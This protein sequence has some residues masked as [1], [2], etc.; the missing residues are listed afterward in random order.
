MVVKIYKQKNFLLEEINMNEIKPEFHHDF[1]LLTHEE[2]VEAHKNG[3][4]VTGFVEKVIADKQVLEVRLGIGLVAILPFAEATIYPLRYSKKKASL[5]P[6]NIRCLIKRK[7]R[8]K[9]TEVNGDFIAVSR[10]QNMLEALE[11]IRNIK[12]TPMYITNVIPKSVFGD[13]GEGIVGKIIINEVCRSHIKNV[14][15]YLS[16][17]Q[18]I[19][20]VILEADDEQRFNVS[21]RQAFK[22][23]CQEDYSTGMVVRGRIGDW[24]NITDTSHYYVNIAPQVSG[25]LTIKAHKHLE[26][27]TNVECIVTGTCEK[28]LYLELA[29]LL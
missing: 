24:I 19:D 28:G 2:I 21:Y 3:C 7:I 1:A 8:V 6:T 27:G 11:Y 4:T 26:Y 15:E 17:G 5:L 10:K 14:R 29:K 13:I 18:T 25:I 12:R 20:V 22:P 23:Y 16:K 9:I